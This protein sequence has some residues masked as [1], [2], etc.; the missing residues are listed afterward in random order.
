MRL[1]Q[2]VSLD[3]LEAEIK[4]GYINRRFH[5]EFPTLATIGYSD[6]CQFDNRWN[7]T[8]VACRGIIYDTE[9]LEVSARPFHKFFNYGQGDAQYDLG[10]PILGAF[11]KFDGSLGIGYTRPDGIIAI[12]TRGS[13]ESE[14]AKHAT[15]HG[16]LADMAFTDG[17]TP[18]FEIVYPDN[19]IV[20][21]YGQRDEL[22]Y[23]GSIV[24]ETGGY[25]QPGDWESAARTLRETLAEP[26]RKN[27]EGFVVWLDSQRAVKIKQEDY[28]ALHRIISSLSRKEVWRQLRAG[29]FLEFATGLPDEFHE[30]AKATAAVIVGK[31][32]DLHFRAWDLKTTVLRVAGTE[33]KAQALWLKANGD[34]KLI[35]FVFNLL[36]GRDIIDSVW[37]AVEPHGASEVPTSELIAAGSNA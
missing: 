6:K 16:S 34:P 37:R 15:A 9:T 36:D 17:I 19:R 13:F 31:S 5:P 18:L 8:T 35:G 10:A 1:D 26:P 33:R 4:A 7:E 24:N 21:D 30:W 32:D 20:L 14:Q 25:I 22:V 23:L 27:A 11:N 29:T 2:I 3:A 12:A 28:V